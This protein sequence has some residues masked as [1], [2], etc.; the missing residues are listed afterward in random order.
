MSPVDLLATIDTVSAWRLYCRLVSMI[1]PVSRRV[2]P[3]VTKKCEAAARVPH[4]ARQ[5]KGPHAAG[6]ADD[7]GR[8]L[9]AA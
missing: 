3:L 2:H 7:G 8:L 5:Q 6:L 9:S 4:G 1:D